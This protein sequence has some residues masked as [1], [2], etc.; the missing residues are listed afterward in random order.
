MRKAGSSFDL[1]ITP[2]ASLAASGVIARRGVDEVLILGELSLDG[3]ASRRLAACCRSRRR[4]RAWRF[5]G[6]LLRRPTAAKPRSSRARLLS[7]Q[8]A[9]GGRQ[10]PERPASGRALACGRRDLNPWRLLGRA[11]PARPPRSRSPRPAAWRAARRSLPGSGK[12]MMAARGRDPA[13]ADVRRGTGGHRGGTLVSGLLAPGDGPSRARPFRAPHTRSGR[14][15][16][17][18]GGSIPRPGI[19]LAHHGVL[20]LDEMPEFSRHALEVLRQPA[21]EDGVVPSASRRRSSGAF[22]LIGAMNPCP[23]GFSR[24]SAASLS[25]HADASRPLAS[26]LSGP[27]QTVSILTVTA[28][29]PPAE[30]TSWDEGGPP[31]R[32]VPVSSPP[33]RSSRAPCSPARRPTRLGRA[34]CAGF[35]WTAERRLLKRTPPPWASPRA[36][37]RICVAHEPTRGVRWRTS[38]T[39]RSLYE[40]CGL[41]FAV[42]SLQFGLQFRVTVR[43]QSL[44]FAVCGWFRVHGLLGDF[45]AGLSKT[46]RSAARRDVSRCTVYRRL[47]R[48][49]S[50][51]D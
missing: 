10:G 31:P 41:R 40:V 43:V 27:L 16:G 2:S 3:A 49:K 28:S 47:F 26:R 14:R 21:L 4:A 6:L 13:A 42:C 8:I 50:A 15:A 29:S 11:G 7:V 5:Q 44:Q 17:G 30:L 36:F 39:S 24:R 51:T 23:C 33:A 25:V 12:T 22:V 19:S 48:S 35:P 45:D 18:R 34:R 37:E 46:Q 20:F 1:P 32:F 38:I 9:H